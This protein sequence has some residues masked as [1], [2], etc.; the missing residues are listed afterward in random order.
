M[1]KRQAPLPIAMGRALARPPSRAAA[2]A[3]WEPHVATAR[4]R[5]ANPCRASRRRP[6]IGRLRTRKAYVSA[7]L[8]AWTTAASARAP[9]DRSGEIA[10]HSRAATRDLGGEAL[11]EPGS[12][13]CVF[14]DR[15]HAQLGCGVRSKRACVRAEQL[16][17]HREDLDTVEGSSAVSFD[18]WTAWATPAAWRI[19]PGYRVL[20]YGHRDGSTLERGGGHALNRHCGAARPTAC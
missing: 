10:W 13:G 3:R 9:L 18:G 17:L 8:V 4:S 5:D 7:L 19:P 20:P 2:G 1:A 11:A 6:A 15:Y 16:A 14:T 12:T